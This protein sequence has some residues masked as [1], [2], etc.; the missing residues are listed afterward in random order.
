MPEAKPRRFFI[1]GR[2]GECVFVNADEYTF[3]FYHDAVKKDGNVIGYVHPF[4]E[5]FVVVL[6]DLRTLCFKETAAA[7]REALIKFC[8]SHN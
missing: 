8:I 4:Y 2:K 3:R 5:D 1:R 6:R 7:G